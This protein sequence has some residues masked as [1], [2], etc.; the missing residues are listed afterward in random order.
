MKIPKEGNFIQEE[1]SILAENDK[2]KDE[3]IFFADNFANLCF[4]SMMEDDIDDVIGAYCGESKKRKSLRKLLPQEDSQLFNFIIEEMNSFNEKGERKKVGECQITEDGNACSIRL[5][6]KNFKRD[7]KY[8]IFLRQRALLVV[9]KVL[10]E[11]GLD[12]TPEIS[13]VAKY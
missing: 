12:I 8:A 2:T 4:R 6:M 10:K 13:M 5:Y 1:G 9:C 3:V 11:F 7:V